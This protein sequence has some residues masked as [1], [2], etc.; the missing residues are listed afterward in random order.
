MNPAAIAPALLG[1]VLGPALQ[2][3]QPD[4]WPAWRY[5]GLALPALVALALLL[6]AR[7]PRWPLVL[8]CA[9]ALCAG[10]TGLRAVAFAAGGLQPLLEGRNLTV[11][12]IVAAMPHRNEAGLRFRFEVEAA[13]DG[14][15]PV[16]L[17]ARLL[18]G[19]YGGTDGGG[20]PQRQ[21]PPELAPGE[22]WELV[23]RLK[24]PHGHVNPHGFDY[25]LWL[26]EQGLQA[27]GYVR[28]GPRD[29]APRRLATTWRQPVE[30]LR[31]RARAA[32]FERV[33]DPRLAGV[34]AALVAGDQ[35]AIELG[36]FFH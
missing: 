19:W 25:E 35:G 30:Q 15:V 14:A 28:A 13:R 36:N 2:L 20:P 11:T 34:L 31:H 12:G 16:T 27:T 22:R 7:R 9:A 4:L 24:A 33:A 6:A 10:T 26:W 29:A 8:L 32:I 17:P 18:L 3:Q 1:A 5:A 23:V 21:P